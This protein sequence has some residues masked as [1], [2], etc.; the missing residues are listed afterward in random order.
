MY[1]QSLPSSAKKF[2]E[3]VQ[4]SKNQY[5]FGV[6]T[7]GDNPCLS[8]EYLDNLLKKKNAYLS[9]GF[10]IRMPYNYL[11]PRVK[12]KDFFKCFKLK[13]LP[14]DEKKKYSEESKKNR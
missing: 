3:K 5:I 11:S 2:I 7:Y 1:H 13:S 14:L 10:S 4:N 6:C 12:V 8:L 9:C